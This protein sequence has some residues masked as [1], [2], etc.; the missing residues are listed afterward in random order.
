MAWG[1]HHSCKLVLLQPLLVLNKLLK[2][3]IDSFVDIPPPP[4]IMDPFLFWLI[5]LLKGLINSF[6]DISDWTYIFFK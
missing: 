3:I 6:V 5:K 1:K 4:R 2:A